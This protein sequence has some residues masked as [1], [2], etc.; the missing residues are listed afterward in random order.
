MDRANQAKEEVMSVGLNAYE[1]SGSSP[2]RRAT[3][4]HVDLVPGHMVGMGR[5]RDA[6]GA[7]VTFLGDW[8][9]LL[10]CT[11]A[12]EAGETIEVFLDSGWI[13]AWRRP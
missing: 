7:E 2:P 1:T 13:V 11:A 8:V 10:H 9:A 5:G 12:L 4:T 3:L 6:E